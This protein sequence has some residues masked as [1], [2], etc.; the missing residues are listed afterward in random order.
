[1]SSFEKELEEGRGDPPPPYSPKEKP[2]TDPTNFRQCL[3]SIWK[4]VPRGASD[5]ESQ[6]E[7]LVICREVYWR[8]F[9]ALSRPHPEDNNYVT[10]Y[11][12]PHSAQDFSGY[13]EPQRVYNGDLWDVEIPG[14][15]GL[16]K[17]CEDGSLKKCGWKLPSPWH[18]SC[19]IESNL[20]RPPKPMYMA[21][22]GVCLFYCG[23]V[24][25]SLLFGT[26]DE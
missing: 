15:I 21:F 12:L 5:Q 20:E 23:A 1:M 2:I 24:C 18:R 16:S 19:V 22:F 25:I 6:E 17:A 8:E 3:A 9:Y 11:K 4:P 13:P 10:E 7:R 26:R 14:D